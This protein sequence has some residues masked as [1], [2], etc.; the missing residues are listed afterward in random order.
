MVNKDS[1]VQNWLRKI[2]DLL[3]H[4]LNILPETNY[5]AGFVLNC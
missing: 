3:K 5:I 2:K 4:H 1:I